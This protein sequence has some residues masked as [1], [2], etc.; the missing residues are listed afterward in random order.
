MIFR[1]VGD[2]PLVHHVRLMQPI[3][4]IL[5]FD[6]L[7]FVIVYSLQYG[8]LYFADG[9]ES[10][11]LYRSVAFAS[12]PLC[13]VLHMSLF[14]MSQWSV[15]I[16]CL[17]GYKIVGHV[18]QAAYVHV[19][20]L[21]TVGKDRIVELSRRPK[22]PQGISLLGQSIAIQ[23]EHF[24]FQKVIYSVNMEKRIVDRLEY[25]TIANARQYL[26]SPGY[27]TRQALSAT[28]K[29]GLNEYDIPLPALLDLYVE[30]LV[31]PFFVFQV[32]CLFL[33]SLDD[34]W[35]YS[36]FTLVMLMFFEGMLCKQRQASLQ[37]LRDMKK[38]SSVMMVYRNNV[39]EGIS[40][41]QLL[42]GDVVSVT[43][44]KAMR[45]GGM[46]ASAQKHAQDED[47][48][49]PCDILLLQG[50]CVVNE[51]ILTGESVPQMKESL[52][53]A[54]SYESAVIDL[55]D[56][57]VAAATW[58]RH[59]LLGGTRLLQYEYKE[60]PGSS[61]PS[62]PNKGCVAIVVRTGFG[63]VQGNLMRKILFATERVNSTSA[64]TF[65]FIGVLV[66]FAILASATVMHGGLQDDT[67]SKFKLVLHCIMIITS[68]VPPELPM[69]L[70]LAVTNSLAA[71]ARNL[72]FCTEPFRIPF[73]GKVDVLCFDKTGTLTKDEMILRGAV[74]ASFAPPTF[75]AS[76]S[77][78]ARPSNPGEPRDSMVITTDVLNLLDQQ[79]SLA[80]PDS[81]VCVM[82]S[83]NSLHCN[84][85]REVIGDPLE[86]ATFSASGFTVPVLSTAKN[87]ISLA[88]LVNELRNLK[89]SVRHR[90]LFSSALKRMS[91]IVTIDELLPAGNN[92]C[93]KTQT[94]VFTKGAP[95]VLEERLLE[96]PTFYRQAYQHHMTN[97]KR[98]LVLA[99][100]RIAQDPVPGG[101]L[102]NF[103]R[104]EAEKNLVFISFLLFDSD[105]KVRA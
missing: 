5:R 22:Q 50:N 38:A 94:W 8:L 15:H 51:A 63:T 77:E 71:L 86:I 39:W 33:W 72:I 2:D 37:Q 52:Y 69:E 59:L 16:K 25:P 90:F 88:T 7:P 56:G 75:G 28:L 99:G 85:N 83:C 68:V 20:A 32:L 17:L 60:E 74:G 3:S 93:S 48:V 23:Q 104:E 97:G 24:E 18:D 64:E 44:A 10:A 82:A 53:C 96:V 12:I 27:T 66:F 105:L 54:E 42:P 102:R 30:H 55:E 78:A 61:I 9:I 67:R 98:V 91:V 84:Q 87:S 95:E 29:W 4:W 35:Y 73:A 58:R 1:T 34:Y 14:L 36:A 79:A 45:P 65:Y 26:E 70:S 13:L 57:H 46:R 89:L 19:V 6:V 11:A 103:P 49:L 31:A 21:E 40:S 92:S 81:V 100:R 43:T 80:C 47:D 101:D 62:P 41:E 76:H